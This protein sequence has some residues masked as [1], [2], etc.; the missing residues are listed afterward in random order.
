MRGGTK[1]GGHTPPSNIGDLFSEGHFVQDFI[2]DGKIVVDGTNQSSTQPPS[3]PNQG[4][5]IFSDPLPQHA[6]WEGK[7][8]MT[9]PQ[10]S[11]I[12]SQVNQVNTSYHVVPPPP[13]LHPT[14]P[15]SASTHLYSS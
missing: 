5:G 7:T 9:D 2:D 15:T 12:N 8:P 1:G 11:G 10:P 14:T 3:N 13:T 6:L 4:M